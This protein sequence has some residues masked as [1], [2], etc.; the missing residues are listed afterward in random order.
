MFLGS[1]FNVEIFI[2]YFIYMFGMMLIFSILCMYFVH[3][4]RRASCALDYLF[5]YTL[6]YH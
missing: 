6:F 4:S 3:V 1:Y 5:V 2:V